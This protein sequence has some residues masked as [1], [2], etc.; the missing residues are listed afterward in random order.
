VDA[1]GGAG[2]AFHVVCPSLPGYGFSGPTRERGWDPER[3]ARAETELMRRLGHARYGA[4]GGDWGAIVTSWI[5]KLDAAHCAGIHDNSG[6]SASG[7]GIA[8]RD[9]LHRVRPVIRP[10]SAP[11]MQSSPV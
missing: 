7:S 1:P 2:E 10:S 4:Q 6:S 8:C 3:I 9:R 11:R 5:G